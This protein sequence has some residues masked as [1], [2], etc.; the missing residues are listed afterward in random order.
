MVGSGGGGVGEDEEDEVV[1]VVVPSS[2]SA[3]AA[4]ATVGVVVVGL[5]TTFCS[6]SQFPSWT[7]Y[8]VPVAH[9]MIVVVVIIPSVQIM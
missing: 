4:A 7:L 3:A 1:V 8:N 5:Q 2:F 6:Q 9:S